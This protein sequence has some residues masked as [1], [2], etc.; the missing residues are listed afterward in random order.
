[1]RGSKR[2]HRGRFRNL[3]TAVA[4]IAIVLLAAPILASCG[5][6]GGGG[7]G[8]S[9]IGPTT[10]LPVPTSTWVSGSFVRDQPGVYGTQ[11]S[12]APSNIP[13]ARES[14]VSWV[15]GAG[16]LWL[17]GGIGFDSGSTLGSLND[18]WR[19]DGA[20]W[21]WVSGGDAVNAAG[22]YGN[23]GE[24]AL[25]NVPGARSDSVSWRDS[26][27]N[28]WLFG[29]AGYDRF[30][31]QGELNDLWKWDGAY[32]IWVSGSDS[33]NAPGVYGTKGTPAAGN[34]PGA[35]DGGVSWSDSDGNLWLF[36]GAGFDTFAAQGVLNDLWKWDGLNWTWV[37]GSDRSY[38][39]GVY[40]IRGVA[41]PG[42]FPGA[43]RGSV[44]WRD[45]AGNLWLFGGYGYDSAGL[46][47]LND[48]WKWDGA[49]WTWVSGA[50]TVNAPGVYGTRGVASTGGVPGARQ[51][52]IG[53]TDSE[54]NFWLFGGSG[55]GSDEAT[56]G[57]LNDLWR[58]DGTGWIWVSGSDTVN[59]T[60]VYGSL[61]F[62][63]TGNFPGARYSGV[64]WID[65]AGNLWLFGG[66]GLDANA[67]EGSLND[68]WKIRP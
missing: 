3:G 12:A 16:S 14:A 9:D 60:G 11:G 34:V 58:W 67:D 10:P 17:F 38:A 6:G 25:G 22:V 45:S 31:T 37:S 63:A 4:R 43:R 29:G 24:A 27:G 28:L 23:I 26:A 8:Q 35:R 62:A 19:W 49:S 52:A 48:L 56:E 41:A 21:T 54:G 66:Y 13:G 47:S 15:D 33:T 18:L 59:A 46:G 39:A 64:S 1:M 50:A 68:L 30:A 51:S 53:W 2:K 61:G 32:W 44:A 40:G 36:G 5:G 57:E 20:K 42:N 65:A 7:G 55:Y